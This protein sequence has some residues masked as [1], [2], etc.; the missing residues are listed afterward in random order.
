MTDAERTR[1]FN[2][3]IVQQLRAQREH[4]KLVREELLVILQNVQDNMT[5]L[6]AAQPSDYLQWFLPQ[7]MTQVETVLHELKLN[8]S[9][10]LSQALE[11]SANAGFAQLDNAL[12][13]AGVLVSGT[14]P[15]VD[16]T[17]LTNIKAFNVNRIADITSR[18]MSAIE[19]ELSSVLIGA[20]SPHD[21]TQAIQKLMSDAPRYRIKSIVHNSL[22]SVYNKS[23]QDRYEQAQDYLPGLKKRWYRSGKR[24][25][26][27]SHFA[28][29][30]QTVP[31]DE[32]YIIGGVAMMFPHDPKAPLKEII[33]CG[34]DSRP[35]M[36]SWEVKAPAHKVDVPG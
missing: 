20:K 7:I 29:H 13:P 5:L 28:A 31:V 22:G 4:V 32:P 14:A 24:D 12:R 2:A 23:A 21:A 15:Y 35:W 3:A 18:A 11:T 27:L 25:P 8:G 34:C 17:L 9:A 33:N 1:L 6:L 26:R 16:A 36:D 30:R 19:L 10:K